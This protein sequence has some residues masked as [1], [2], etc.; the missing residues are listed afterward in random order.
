MSPSESAQHLNTDAAHSPIRK[1]HFALRVVGT[2]IDRDETRIT[3]PDHLMDLA[4][5]DPQ[6]LLDKM[7]NGE[8]DESVLTAVLEIRA[9]VF[10]SILSQAVQGARLD[11]LTGLPRRDAL[12]K[13]IKK[14][15]AGYQ[16]SQRSDD[17]KPFAVLLL[18][19][20]HFKSVNDTYGHAEGD[21][22][23]QLVAQKLTETFRT[24]DDG[25][26]LVVRYGGEEFA[27]V[28]DGVKS[29][30]EMQTVMDKIHELEFDCGTPVGVITASVGGRI[31]TKSSVGESPTIESLIVE[32]DEQL[33]RVKE[34]SDGSDRDGYSF[35]SI[36][37]PTMRIKRHANQDVLAEEL[38]EL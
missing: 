14:Y 6:L 29:D 1:P 26:D 32:T 2:T 13:K 38:T 27:I 25:E 28:A 12:E 5:N 33:Y 30:Q 7:D 21:K 19:V 24:G 34:E 22:A 35:A 4:E 23:L 31:C 18:D 9:E 16:D 37:N 20:D 11:P 8:V 17:P 15:L 36:S 3:T 10:L